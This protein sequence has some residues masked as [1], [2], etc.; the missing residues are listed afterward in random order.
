MGPIAKRL[1]QE[2]EE[3]VRDCIGQLTKDYEKQVAGLSSITSS[4]SSPATLTPE[5]TSEPSPSHIPQIGQPRDHG[6]QESIYPKHPEIEDY[7]SQTWVE[8]L[9]TSQAAQGPFDSLMLSAAEPSSTSEMQDWNNLEL[10]TTQ[11]HSASDSYE[12]PIILPNEPAEF[13]GMMSDIP[14]ATPPEEHVH[15]EIEYAG[16]GKGRT[17]D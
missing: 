12:Y 8:P 5:E 17:G 6:V 10:T 4:T 1:K 7:D 2:M 15:I 11:A 16:K 13:T 14:S 9:W 3:I